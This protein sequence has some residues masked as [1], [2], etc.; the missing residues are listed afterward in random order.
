MMHYKINYLTNGTK[1]KITN[2]LFN[3]IKQ[4]ETEGVHI[5]PK[6]LDELKKQDDDWIN[7]SRRYYRH[8]VA[9]ESLSIQVLNQQKAL[10]VNSFQNISNNRLYINK[11]LENLSVCTD[12]QIRRFLMYYYFG[13]S[14]TSISKHEKC[15]E[16]AVRKSIRK[17]VKRIKISEKLL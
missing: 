1:V 10:R 8:T 13:Y 4:W 7:N 3:Q 15:S 9:I 17:V 5:N 16:G 11:I 14:L 12:A 6:F 2:Q